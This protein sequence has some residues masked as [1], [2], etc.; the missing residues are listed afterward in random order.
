MKQNIRVSQIVAVYRA[1]STRSA[2]A[3]AAAVEVTINISFGMSCSERGP[4]RPAGSGPGRQRSY[5]G[6]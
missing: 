5:V 2:D 3:P 6:F 1:E 4:L